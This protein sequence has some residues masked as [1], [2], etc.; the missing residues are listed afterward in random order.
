MKRHLQEE[1]REHL[2]NYKKSGLTVDAYC[3]KANIAVSTFW[4]WHRKYRSG[5]PAK[6]AIPFLRLPTAHLSGASQF[7]IVFA[8][9]TRLKV[10]SGFDPDSLKT[11]IAVLR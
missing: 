4:N 7:E 1:I 11:L 2:S 3:S 8:N 5:F 9:N 6:S 10:P